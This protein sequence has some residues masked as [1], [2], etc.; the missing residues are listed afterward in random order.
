MKKLFI[1]LAFFLPLTS[2]GAIAR[3]NC[4]SPAGNKGSINT[5]YTTGTLT[6][7]VMIFGVQ[8]NTG[9]VISG[10]P[11]YGGQ[12]MTLIGTFNG[13]GSVFNTTYLYYLKNPPSGANTLIANGTTPFYVY[14]GVATYSGVDQTTPIDASGTNSGS[15]TSLSKSLTTTND[16]DWLV[17]SFWGQSTGVSISAGSGT[18]F[19]SNL[20]SWAAFGDSN[21][22]VGSAGSYALA[23]SSVGTENLAMYIAA[24]KPSGVSAIPSFQLWW[25][26]I[27]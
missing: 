12:A 27:F 26:S 19:C 7:G 22:P 1:I 5:S 23:M 17:G 9:Y 8:I 2:F 18:T 25:Q 6:D 3:D 21:G 20:G 11:T 14:G 13:G 16:G 4:A 15:G 10:T 24:L